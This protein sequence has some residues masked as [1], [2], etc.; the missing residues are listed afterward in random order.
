ML[1]SAALRLDTSRDARSANQAESA[2]PN[3]AAV[4]L[5]TAA[6]AGLP[7]VVLT[8]VVDLTV[9]DRM[10]AAAEQDEEQAVVA[11]ALRP[12]SV[13]WLP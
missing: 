5:T 13:A 10:A 8:V 4:V 1:E 12:K 7:V 9:A 2:V 6:D 3:T 11:V